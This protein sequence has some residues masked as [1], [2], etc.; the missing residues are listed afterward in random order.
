MKGR[1]QPGDATVETQQLDVD[2][3]IT[4]SD[5][6]YVCEHQSQGAW[7]EERGFL[8][9]RNR[10]QPVVIERRSSHS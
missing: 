4:L 8:E 1:G 10:D 3:F 7:V 9:R 5:H 6:R 2:E